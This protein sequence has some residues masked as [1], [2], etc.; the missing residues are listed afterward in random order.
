MYWTK[1]YTL[2]ITY[3]LKTYFYISDRRDHHTVR[4]D[5]AMWPQLKNVVF[6][7]STTL[8]NPDRA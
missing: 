5:N 3:A 7:R 6:V 2:Y 8:S 4:Y 1:I